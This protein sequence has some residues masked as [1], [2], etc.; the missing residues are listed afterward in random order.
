MSRQKIGELLRRHV[1]LTSHDIDEI[2][3]EQSHT[4]RRFGDVAMSLGLCTPQDVWRAWCEQ[5]KD[6]IEHVDLDAMGIDAQAVVL[7]PREL[8]VKFRVVPV[9]C[10]DT[11]LV[12]ATD[13][14]AFDVA[15]AEAPQA[16]NRR[17]RFVIAPRPQLDR[18][19][20][21]YYG[22]RRRAG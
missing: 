6:S 5:V 12:L 16:L 20:S 15:V 4:R 9:R 10:T 8:A 3:H 13:D 14:E 19:I 22:T 18:A 21:T 17:I 1:P 2:L 7:V 11:H